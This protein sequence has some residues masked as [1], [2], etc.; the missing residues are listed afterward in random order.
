MSKSVQSVYSSLKVLKP[1]PVYPMSHIQALPMNRII[2]PIL[3]GHV[4]LR[5][6]MVVVAT[7]ILILLCKVSTSSINTTRGRTTTPKRSVSIPSPR[8]D[9]LRRSARIEM[10]SSQASASRQKDTNKYERKCASEL[11]AFHTNSQGFTTTLRQLGAHKGLAHY[12]KDDPVEKLVKDIIDLCKQ[13]LSYITKIC[14]YIP[15]SCLDLGPST[16]PLSRLHLSY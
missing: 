16:S 9:A 15:H 3:L 10:Y 4:Y 5:V 8:N 11:T 2:T 6:H 1:S 14:D 13:V 12:D 7:S